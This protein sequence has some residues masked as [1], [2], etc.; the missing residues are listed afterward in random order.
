MNKYYSYGASITTPTNSKMK[1]NTN[2][3]D[4]SSILSPNQDS[5]NN[6]KKYIKKL[7][8][9]SYQ[10]K[11]NEMQ[12]GNNLEKKEMYGKIFERER[13]EEKSKDKPKETIKKKSKG[14]NKKF[15]ININNDNKQKNGTL[16]TSNSNA[17]IK[18]IKSI[19]NNEEVNPVLNCYLSPKNNNSQV[20]NNF[21]SINLPAPVK[22]I[23]FFKK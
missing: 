7:N 18:H 8:V 4:P 21:Y 6:S 2:E 1:S 23:N 10:Q 16:L 20:F 19:N 14:L 3:N 11:L 9:K 15:N 12:N 13:L 22:V 17:F 5:N